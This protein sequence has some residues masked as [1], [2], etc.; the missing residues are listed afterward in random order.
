MMMKKRP[1]FD[2][3]ITRLFAIELPIVQGA[4]AW[5]SEAE[6]VAAVSNAGGLGVLGASIMSVDEFEVQV[7]RAKSLTDRPFAV[8]FPLVLGHYEE[9]LR[10][11]LSYGVRIIFVS[12]G[13]PKVMT[14]PIHSAG[15]VCV[16]VVPNLKL[17]KKVSDAGVDAVV[18][19]SFE[20]GGHVSV[21]GITAITNI[22]NVA[23]KLNKPLI[24]AGGIVDGRGLAA[25]LSLGADAVQMG[26]RFL[27]TQENNAHRAYK[28]LLLEADEGDALVYG[29]RHHPGRALR[30]NAIEQIVALETNGGTIE[31]VRN[32]IGRG[33]ARKAAHHGDLEQGMFYSGAGAGNIDDEPTVSEL[34]SRIV[35]EFVEATQR[36]A[37]FLP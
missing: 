3:R 20:A 21:E 18:L 12:A 1:R 25:A 8:N 28:D 5:L 7:V 22:P 31:D 6:L 14:H 19:E 37:S 32:F 2:T 15:A 10:M 30:S 17:A 33:R 16:H 4:M 9:H 36:L 29:L 35:D 24:A 23:K 11:S 27:A 34:M 26:T 13:S